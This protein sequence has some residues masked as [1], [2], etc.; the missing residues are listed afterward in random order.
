MSALRLAPRDRRMLIIGGPMICALVLSAKTLP[1]ALQWQRAQLD[2]V[3]AALDRL[4]AAR[5]ST[6]ML[7]ALR[8]SFAARRARVASLDT[9][10]IG[11][12]SPVAAAGTVATA[13]EDLAD[14]A[15]VRVTAVQIRAD[16][17]VRAGLSRVGV[18][19]VGVCDVTGLASLLRA[20][21]TD[22][23][24]MTV[25]DL[26]VTQPDPVGA[27]TKAETLRIDVGVEALVRIQ[28][29]EKR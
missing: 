17:V 13:L 28:S 26:A 1:A 4:S 20:I 7:P 25:R 11:G 8:D 18:R 24:A 2:S 22:A 27:S 14:D 6:A 15:N 12:P 3:A 10:L 21:E 16:T 5:R 23:R 19:L 29:S 9:L